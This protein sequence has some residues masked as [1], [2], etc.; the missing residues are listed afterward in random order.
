MSVSILQMTDRVS[1]LLARKYRVP[2]PLDRQAARLARRLPRKLREPVAVLAS[3]AYMAQNPK[4][5]P[6]IDTQAVAAAYDLALR[7][8]TADERARARGNLWV[9]I[10]GSIAFSLLVVAVGVLAVLRWRGYL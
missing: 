7:T 10:A 1:E 2:G 4:L 6:Q 5:S 9:G 3:A 8:L